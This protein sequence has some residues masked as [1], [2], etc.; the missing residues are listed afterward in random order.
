MRLLKYL[1]EQTTEKALEW[2]K[3][4]TAEE[5]GKGHDT[6][7]VLN[8]VADASDKNVYMWNENKGNFDTMWNKIRHTT[9]DSGRTLY[10]KDILAGKYEILTKKVTVLPSSQSNQAA[11]SGVTSFGWTNDWFNMELGSAG[12]TW[13]L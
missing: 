6:K 4:P 10:H 13:G 5:I 2:H 1:K 12:A 8:W 7:S 11:N 9:T 3:N